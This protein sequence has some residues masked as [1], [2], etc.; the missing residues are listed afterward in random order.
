MS[1]PSSS[2]SSKASQ[3]E[4]RNVPQLRTVRKQLFS[5]VR[6]KERPKEKACKATASLKGTQSKNTQPKSPRGNQSK[7]SQP[8][9]NQQV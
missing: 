6:E 3:N 7:N 9:L 5:D 2:A 4:I 1:N 8:N